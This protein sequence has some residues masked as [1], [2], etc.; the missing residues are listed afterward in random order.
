MKSTA[1]KQIPNSKG[2]TCRNSMEDT[3]YPKTNRQI[4]Q[5]SHRSKCVNTV[6]GDFKETE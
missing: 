4:K 6:G 5:V 1:N 3:E 2:K